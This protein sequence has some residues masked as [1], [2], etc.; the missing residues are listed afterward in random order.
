MSTNLL[1]LAK[2]GDSSSGCGLVLL[3]H[4][5]LGTDPVLATYPDGTSLTLSDHPLVTNLQKVANFGAAVLAM[6]DRPDEPTYLLAIAPHHG[7]AVQITPL[8]KLDMSAPETLAYLIRQG[9]ERHPGLSLVLSLQGH[10]AGYTPELDASQIT[11]A[12]ATAD[13]VRWEL[14]DG[15]LVPR[16]P[17]GSPVIADGSPILPIATP[18]SANDHPVLSTWAIG[19]GLAA[20]SGDQRCDRIA[21][22][23]FNNCFNMSAE[24]LHT[25][26]AHA[27]FAVGYCNYN[28]F[29]AGEA[30]PRVFQNLQA[31]GEAPAE[32]VARW[33]A[34]TNRDLL[35]AKGNHPTVGGVIALSRMHEITER[36]DDLADALLAALRTSPNRADEVAK[37]KKAIVAAQ[38]YDTQAGFV[39]EAPDQLTDLCSFAARLQEHDFGPYGVKAAAAALQGA[40]KGIKAY[41]SADAP[42]VDP[43]VQ[44]DFSEETLAMN[45]LLPDP[46]LDGVWD[47][48]SPYYLD[49]NPDPNKPPVQPHI[50]DFL[51]V[52]DWVDFIIEYH[53]GV[54]FKG[55][56]PATIPPYPVFNARYDP[57]GCGDTKPQGGCRYGRVP[58][59][60]KD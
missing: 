18:T 37:I 6:I 55:L 45:I 7:A 30:Y 1:T 10:G 14:A 52:T 47:W 56:L 3:V 42:W 29:T 32:Q 5:P 22:V 40:L 11:F 59:I 20:A 48:R 12:N 27:D 33:F 9:R 57:R 28:F 44:W 39:L 16:R 58:R 21:V 50:I 36:L 13:G 38:Q 17:D 31:A 53:K 2:R 43:G 54:P 8:G 46:L 51:K 49:V 60:S 4:A 26:A 35:A 19:A 41:G 34:E 24:L 25:V 15:L 23:H